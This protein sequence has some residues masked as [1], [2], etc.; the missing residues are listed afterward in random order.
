M[1]YDVAKARSDAKEDEAVCGQ[2]LG[3]PHPSPH[4]TEGTISKRG[5]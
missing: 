2:Q 1:L 4:G 3:T 5:P